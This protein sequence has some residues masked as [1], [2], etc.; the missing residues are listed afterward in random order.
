MSNWF[1]AD[2]AQQR[3]GPV[4]KEQLCI[5]FQQNQISESN[6]VWTQGMA[7]WQ[8]LASV[9]DQLGITVAPLPPPMPFGATGSSNFGYQN[10][11]GALLVKKS[12]GTSG[13]LI[14]VIVGVAGLVVLSILA[15]IALPAYQDYTVRARLTNVLYQAKSQRIMVDEFYQSNQ[16]CPET[17]DMQFSGAFQGPGA[18]PV[19]S[20]VMANLADGSCA[21]VVTLTSRAIPNGELNTLTL[22]RNTDGRWRFETSIPPKYLPLAMRNSSELN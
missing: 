14:A 1:Y 16:R 5:A 12:G 15:A 3:R 6:L 17:G 10:A 20:R 8:T 2:Q 19:Q 18:D 22:I 9:A 4:T 13:C 11:N 7:G 21:M